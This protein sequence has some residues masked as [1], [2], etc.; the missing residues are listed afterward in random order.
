MKSIF[1]GQEHSEC[2]EVMCNLCV[3]RLKLQ[4]SSLAYRSRRLAY[5]FLEAL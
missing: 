2:K 5:N 1:N 4:I 3:F